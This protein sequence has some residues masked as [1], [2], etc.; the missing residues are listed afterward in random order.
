[1]AISGEAVIFHGG[2]SH[3]IM[4]AWGVEEKLKCS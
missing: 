1:M 2:F 3:S 4:Q